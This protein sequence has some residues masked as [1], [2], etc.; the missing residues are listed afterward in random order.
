MSGRE[1]V[2]ETLFPTDWNTYLKASILTQQEFDRLSS[3]EV[4]VKDPIAL[5][6][7]MEE[8]DI[9]E[10]ASTLQC[11]VAKVSDPRHLHRILFIIR[12]LLTCNCHFLSLF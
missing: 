12:T 10:Y 7:K 5:V 1:V 2:D 4:F 9:V 11:V 3:I 6:S 8:L